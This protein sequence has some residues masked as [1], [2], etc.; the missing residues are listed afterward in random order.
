MGVVKVGTM[1][2]P[3]DVL[4]GKVTPKNKTELSPEEKLCMR[5]LVVPV[6]M[7]VMTR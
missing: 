4:V 1:V 5:S 6:K 3:G 7:S 2:R